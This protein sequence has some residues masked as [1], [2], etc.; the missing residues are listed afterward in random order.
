MTADFTTLVL[1]DRPGVVC[2][3]FGRKP[4]RDRNNRYKHQDWTE[5]QFTWPGEREAMTRAVAQEMVDGEP[6]DV[7][8][9][10]AV[11]Q[12]GAKK[13]RKGDALPPL[14]LWFDLDGPPSDQAFLDQLGALI[15]ASGQPGH[16]HGYVP[17]SRPIDLGTHAA[18][19]KALAARLG[20][21]AKWSDESL[22]RLPGTW[23]WKPTIPPDG[24]PAGEKLLVTVEQAATRTWDPAD[25]AAE[26][27]VG[28]NA[29]MPATVPSAGMVSAEP[30]PSPLPRL[31]R[32]A[33]EYS[34]TDRS[35]AHA[36]LVGACLDAH[37]TLGQTLA[38][39]A[40]YRPSTEK[41][42]ARLGEEVTRFWLK[43]LDERQRQS[44][45]QNGQNSR[46]GAGEGVSGHFGH[47]SGDPWNETPTPLGWQPRPLPTD[48]LGPVLGPLADA[49]AESYQVPADL[50]VNLALPLITTAAGGR[51]TV[52]IT[53]DWSE[54]LALATLSALASGERKSPVM[55][56]LADPLIHHERA[57]LLEARPRIGEQ[58]AKQKIAEDRAEKLRKDAVKSGL[59]NDSQI[60]RRRLPE[61]R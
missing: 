61:P 58:Q 37:L 35:R 59:D 30:L 57:A 46:P 4:Y 17:L 40:T 19:N 20:A 11:R 34:E 33:L 43:A 50:A 18:L 49:I 48:A 26:L 38:V 7:Y 28:T 25:L 54:T 2:L 6:V 5:V 15:V 13:R 44:H 56:V 9:C 14:S 52:Q 60:V 31:V 10:P 8:V 47:A 42:G 22:L 16:R 1:G 24:T 36:R 21:D 32:W 23:N 45:G 12:G 53:P 39:A 51:W 29:T 27:G 3:A 41:Y 55:R